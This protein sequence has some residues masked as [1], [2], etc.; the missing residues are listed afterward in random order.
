[1][2]TWKQKSSS[3]RVGRPRLPANKR[4]DFEVV[5]KV[6]R[7]ERALL[8]Q[9]REELAP[10]IRGLALKQAA[11]EIAARERLTGKK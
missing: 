3:R 9:A 5:V 6:S 8:Q 10:W 7:E 1:M 11:I 2:G 4:R